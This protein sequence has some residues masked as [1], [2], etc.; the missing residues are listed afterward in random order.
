MSD[1]PVTNLKGVG[2]HLANKLAALH[3]HTVDDLIFHLPFK[4][5]DR[6]RLTA[7]GELKAGNEVLFCAQI[8]AVSVVYGRR[9][10]LIAKVS[11]ATGWM[12]IR[13]FHF[14]KSQHQ[15]MKRQD[16]IFG[17][18]MVRAGRDGF[19]MAHPEYQI[20]P[21]KPENITT[22]TLTPIYP[23][24][25]GISQQR[26]RTLVGMSLMRIDSL[27]DFLKQNSINLDLPELHGA[28]KTVHAPESSSDADLL[29]E[30]NHPAQKRLA[31]EELLAHHLSLRRIKT[32]RKSA[33]SPRLNQSFS[34]RGKFLE[35]LEFELTAAQQ[36]VIREID[37]DINSLS[38][39]QRLVQ[40]DVGSGK[41]VVAA[42]VVC[43][44]LDCGYQAAIMAPTELLAE[45]HLASFE[46]WF[47]PL[48]IKVAWLSGRISA[49][50]RRQVLERLEK[51]EAGLVIGTHALFQQDVK[52]HKLGLVV[53]D[54][55]HRFGVN[56]R[57]ALIEKGNLDGYVPHQLAMTATPIP[58]TLAM[59]FYADM[60]VSSIDE[61]P[62]GRKSVDTILV[63]DNRRG[64]VVERVLNA[65]RLSRQAY[66]V[67]PMIDES[68]VI[69][70]QAATE[71]AAELTQILTEL[72]IGLIH[73]RM[74]RDEKNDIMRE[75]RD[76]KI[77][78]L[79]A[80][81]VIEVGVDVPNASLMIIENSERLGLAQLHQLRGRIGRGEIQSCCVLMYH[82]PL[83]ETAKKR[84]SVM[85]QTNDGFKI[86]K[87]DL[88]L[89]G[90]G[91]V[92]GTRQTGLQQ[93]KIANL[94]RDQGLIPLVEKLGKS[95]QL[96]HEQATN[97][98]IDRW[99]KDAERFADV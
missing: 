17:F 73:G 74:S 4:Y 21:K 10:T 79:V 80:T 13:W 39:M 33:S 95:F 93:L 86:S 76:Q 59:I 8:E 55:Q 32:R 53:V 47:V 67:C 69:Q 38:T 18:G 46:S 84:L 16:W 49:A 15:K 83:S 63:S 98:L 90:P 72:T 64:E 54:E 5:Q 11:D 71:I 89:R 56:Q 9:R 42:A 25:E 96:K 92:F 30:S 70:A 60:D 97:G 66:W 14:T 27:I 65:C 2:K 36:R 58:R 31:L 99:V 77:D 75:F 62:P 68:D 78:V 26:M 23:L 50:Q 40:G 12:T 22:P 19:E 20:S 61:L 43:Q 3:I 52:F 81:T 6:T 51:G 82:P 44:A 45:Q 57:L 34:L 1:N 94:V 48:G 35:Q 24:T 91:E 29:I 7:L 41:T 85:R 88:E 87:Y 37:E 28:L